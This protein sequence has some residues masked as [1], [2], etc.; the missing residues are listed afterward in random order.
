[1]LKAQVLDEMGSCAVG[2]LPNGGQ[3]VRKTI[4]REAREVAASEYVRLTFRKERKN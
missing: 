3:L 4:K 2:N 1:M